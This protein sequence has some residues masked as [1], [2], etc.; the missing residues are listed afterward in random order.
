MPVITCE[1]SDE[2]AAQLSDAAHR[3]GMSIEDYA[4]LAA[5]EAIASRYRLTEV[6]GAVIPFES[7][8]SRLR[9]PPKP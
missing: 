8:N 5:S 2:Q 3:A 4:E 1:L 6:R 9:G 7:L